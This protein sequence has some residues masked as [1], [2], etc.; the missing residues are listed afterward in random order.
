M[1]NT[2]LALVGDTHGN[3]RALEAVLADVFAQLG[4]DALIYNLGDIV[5]YGPRPLECLRLIMAKAKASVLGNHDKAILF[6]PPNFNESAEKALYWCRNQMERARDLDDLSGF[7]G[8]LP[9]KLEIDGALLVHGSPRNPTNEYVQAA[10][11]INEKMM[12]GIADRMGLLAFNGHTHRPGVLT[13][14]SHPAT[15]LS[16]ADITDELVLPE[17]MKHL[18]NVGSVGQPRDGV[19]LACYLI[20]SPKR[21]SIRYRRVP[22]DIEGTMKEII[23]IPDLSDFY[24]HRLRDGR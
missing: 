2:E 5:G 4:K 6:D 24:A 17:G 9:T 22:Y 10:D 3:L 12:T 13:L 16:Q 11:V 8:E 20:Y 15:F 23:A 1:E 14:G 19:A 18:V 7:V 21:R